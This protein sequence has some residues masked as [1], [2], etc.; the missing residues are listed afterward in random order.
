MLCHFDKDFERPKRQI[1]SDPLDMVS[2][3]N[4][5][6]HDW[7]NYVLTEKM[8]PIFTTYYS[9]NYF[10]IRSTC[11]KTSSE[12]TKMF[13]SRLPETTV[14]YASAVYQDTGAIRSILTKCNLVNTKFGQLE[15]NDLE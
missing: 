1:N 2:V 7:P 3:F 11:N 12:L 14:L 15:C 8:L 9:A 10:T 4:G 5:L 13:S 6:T